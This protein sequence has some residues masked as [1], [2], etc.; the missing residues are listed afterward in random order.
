MIAGNSARLVEKYVLWNVLTL[1]I[2]AALAEKRA[3]TV[4]VYSRG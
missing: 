4:V 2:R 3:V 1:T